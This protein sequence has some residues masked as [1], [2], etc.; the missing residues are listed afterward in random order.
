MPTRRS[1]LMQKNVSVYLG[2]RDGWQSEVLAEICSQFNLTESEFFRELFLQ[3]L[4][5]WGLYSSVTREP[6][7]A[8]VDRLKRRRKV[9]VLPE[10][11]GLEADMAETPTIHEQVRQIR[12]GDNGS[13]TFVSGDVKTGKVR[14]PDEAPQEESEGS[15]DG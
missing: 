6:V 10:T 12:H 3:R 4:A 15:K 11:L 5:G 14:D 7:W 8:A 1:K 9:P 13:G 2:R